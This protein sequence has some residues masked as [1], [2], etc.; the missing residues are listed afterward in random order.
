MER[1]KRRG[2]E[3]ERKRETKSLVSGS[4]HNSSLVIAGER[5]KYPAREFRASDPSPPQTFMHIDTLSP[6]KSRRCTFSQLV[7]PSS[8]G[9]IFARP[10]S[11]YYRYT[12]YRCLEPVQRTPVDLD[13]SHESTSVF[14]SGA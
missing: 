5:T 9:E 8:S 12:L 10:L 7:E 6:R 13:V 4:I 14:P 1:D 11:V 2:T 3:D